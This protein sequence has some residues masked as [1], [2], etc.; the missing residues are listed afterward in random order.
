MALSGKPLLGCEYTNEAVELLCASLRA[1]SCAIQTL[2]IA[3]SRVNEEMAVQLARALKECSRSGP[4]VQTLVL[5]G[6]PLPVPQLIGICELGQVAGVAV[7]VI[8]C[9]CCV[10][11]CG[12]AHLCDPLGRTS[13]S[14]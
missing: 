11:R 10:R 2:K 4:I 12:G 6:S 13:T 1:P 5:E 14:G 8:V 3:R 9:C 7:V